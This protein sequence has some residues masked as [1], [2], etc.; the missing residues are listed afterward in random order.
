MR[1]DDWNGN[2]QGWYKSSIFLNGGDFVV[3][4]KLYTWDL[5]VLLYENFT[6]I[7]REH[8]EILIVSTCNSFK[9]FAVKENGQVQPPEKQLLGSHHT[10]LERS[11]GGNGYPLQYSGLK[12][13]VDCIVHGVAKSQTWLSKFHFI[14]V[15]SSRV[16]TFFSYRF[17]MFVKFILFLL[18]LEMVHFLA[19]PTPIGY[20]HIQKLVIFIHYLDHL[21]LNESFFKI[22]SL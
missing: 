19:L 7:K 20:C 18:L 16:L 9:N 4:S 1:E 6:S 21:N 11:P 17:N 14:S 10:S 15:Q 22:F 12:N 5:S 13:S 3:L 2:L 8:V